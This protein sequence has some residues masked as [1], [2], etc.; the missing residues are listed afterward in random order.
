M[1]TD[2]KVKQEVLILTD[3][4]SNCGGDAIEAAKQLQD[5]ADVFALV[6][7]NFSASGVD[8]LTKYVSEPISK[9]LFAVKQLQDFRILVETVAEDIAHGGV[10][11]APFDLGK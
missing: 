6:I 4:Q 5:T 8:E 9:H 2:G 11:C 1:R 3:G 7:G 10:V